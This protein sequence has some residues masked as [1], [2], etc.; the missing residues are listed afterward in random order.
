MLV[1]I[2]CEH[3]PPNIPHTNN[4]A[5]FSNKT[6]RHSTQVLQGYS[7]HRG[8][9]ATSYAVHWETPPEISIDMSR[10]REV[11]LPLEKVDQLEQVLGCRQ[12]IE[13]ASQDA[14]TPTALPSPT[15]I[16]LSHL[17]L[18]E[19]ASDILLAAV[20]RPESSTPHPSCSSDL[21]ANDYPNDP[22]LLYS[23]QVDSDEDYDSPTPSPHLS[24]VP[25]LLRVS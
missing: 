7:Y 23:Q 17:S 13:Y 9:N 6:P 16:L 25:H 19:S 10:H 15:P 4:A 22:L 11:V 5:D 21:G 1:H 12:V 14:T 20:P 18:Q 2:F 24:P 3:G 8:I